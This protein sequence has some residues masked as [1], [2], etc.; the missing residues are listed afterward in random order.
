[1][2]REKQG[3]GYRFSWIEEKEGKEFVEPCIRLKSLHSAPL[4]WDYEEP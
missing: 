1:M 3:I 2:A 4:Q